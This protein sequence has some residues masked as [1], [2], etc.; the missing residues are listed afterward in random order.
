LNLRPQRRYWLDAATTT[1]GAVTAEQSLVGAMGCAS[2]RTRHRLLEYAAV[3]PAGRII[4]GGSASGLSLQANRDLG[5]NE[6]GVTDSVMA[7]LWRFGPTGAAYAVSS[8]AESNHLGADIAI[9][10]SATNRVLLYQAKLARQDESRFELKSHATNDQIALLEQTSVYLKGASFGV[11]GHLAL[12]QADMAPFL[13]RCRSD[14]WFDWWHPWRWHPGWPSRSFEPLPDVGRDYYKEILSSRGCSPSGV[15]AAAVT[16]P[17]PIASVAISSTWPWEFD[18]HE[19]LQ[20]ASRI[21]AGTGPHGEADSP[22]LDQPPEFG[23]YQP[24]PREP[25]E[26]AATFADQLASQLNLPVTRQLFVVVL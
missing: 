18:T 5:L 6:V 21:D 15:L 11:T 8:G 1:S 23:P 19:W 26:D 24:S 10:H 13:D 2:W 4:R 14:L 9:V 22:H 25:P 17:V 20:G 7:A 12:Y 16:G 3:A